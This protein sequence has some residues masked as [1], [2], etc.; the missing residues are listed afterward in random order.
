MRI[1]NRQVGLMRKARQAASFDPFELTCLL[2]G[3]EDMVQERRAAFERVETLLET[4]D[5]S[6]LPRSYGNM[7]REEAYEEGL[8]MGKATFEDGIRHGHDVFVNI[9]P[10]YMLANSSFHIPFGMHRIM[11][12]PALRLM[13]SA[14]QLRKW[15]PLSESGKIIGAY[16]QTEL[17]HGTF[18]R[19]LET[20]ATFDPKEDEFVLH[21]PTRSS[22]KFWP[23]ALG[24]SCTHAIVVARLLIATQDHGLHFFIVQLRSL[25]DGTPLPGIVLGDVGLK[26]AY[27][28]TCNG[29]ATFVHAR[30]PR[31]N[32][33]MGHAQVDR[34]GRYSG[35]SSPETSY[36]TMLKVRGS[37]VQVVSHQLA[38]ALTIATRYSVVREQGMGPNGLA[39]VE[40]TLMAYRSQ[41]FRLFTLTSKAFG[42]FF[43]SKAFDE[44]YVKLRAQQESGDNRELPYMHSLVSGLKAWAT[45]TAADGTEDARKCCG[46]HGYLAISGLPEIVGAVAAMPTFEG[47]N[48]VLWQQVGR[49]LFKCLDFLKSGRPIDSRVAYL[50]DSY[51]QY[52]SVDGQTADPSTSPPC[53]A[54]GRVFLNRD[55]QLP[56]YSHRASRL[57]CDAYQK[58]RS[59]PRSPAEAWNDHMIL[60]IGAARAHIEYHL[61]CTFARTIDNLSSSTSSSLK[62]TLTDLHNLFTLSAIIDPTTVY[63]SSFVE[64]GYLSTSQVDTIRVLTNELL[65]KLVPNAIALTDAWDFTDASLCSALGMKDGNVYENIMRWVEQMPINKR[66]WDEND[67]VYQPGWNQWVKPV[68]RARL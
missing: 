11:F 33:L 32:M 59:S 17:G 1:E 26:M 50:A 35:A 6:K 44:E 13:A 56:M 37:I 22:I 36:A 31:E 27:N 8:Q 19:G 4:Q 67:G 45:Q 25:E 28:G 41:Q 47:D 61:V 38:Q 10:R 53:A 29:F 39:T 2:Y 66:A 65:D 5:T 60:I 55:I 48:Y 24:F 7:N 3:G 49:Y 34:D 40:T 18:L 63:A 43:A 21:C 23:G 62:S 52:L 14:E 30:I 12:D 58:V 64:N 57:I 68:L 15:L 42:I 51:R 20:T 9:T 46:G 54:T 16:C